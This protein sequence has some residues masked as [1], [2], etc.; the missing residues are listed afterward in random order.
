MFSVQIPICWPSVISLWSR[1]IYFV[2]HTGCW[3]VNIKLVVCLTCDIRQVHSQIWVRQWRQICEIL[4]PL[5]HLITYTTT[6]SFTF[7]CIWFYCRVELLLI[8]LPTQWR[9]WIIASLWVALTMNQDTRSS[10]D[11]CGVWLLYQVERS[12]QFGIMSTVTSIW[13]CVEADYYLD[14][15]SIVIRASSP[16][17]AFY[18]HEMCDANKRK[19]IFSSHYEV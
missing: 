6:E 17:F 2:S 16:L 5:R 18:I 10:V 11:I 15:Y 13:C 7:W 9:L 14:Q 3:L 4:A 12:H 19:R 1:K 8:A